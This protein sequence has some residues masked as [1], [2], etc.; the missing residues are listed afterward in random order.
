MQIKGTDIT[1]LLVYKIYD[2][3]E[4]IADYIDIDPSKILK[5]N[6]HWLIFFIILLNFILKDV[7]LSFTNK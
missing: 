6:F 3:F 1:L 5:S 2:C 4:L 7:L